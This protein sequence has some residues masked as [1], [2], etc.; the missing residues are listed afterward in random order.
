MVLLKEGPG[1][2]QV[3]P[4]PGCPSGRAWLGLSSALPGLRGLGASRDRVSPGSLTQ[5]MKH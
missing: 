1:L 2:R 3:E 5:S 4:G